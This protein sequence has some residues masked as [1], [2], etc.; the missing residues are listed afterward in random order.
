MPGGRG[1]GESVGT[2]PVR[3]VAI[4][5]VLLMAFAAI[6]AALVW[7]WL[8]LRQPPLADPAPVIRTS[9]AT[10]PVLELCGIE[11]V[12]PTTLSQTCGD[13]SRAWNNVH[14]WAWDTTAAF[15]VGE[16]WITQSDGNSAAYPVRLELSTASGAPTDTAG[17]TTS[18]TRATGPTDG[19]GRTGRSGNRYTRLTMTYSAEA[20]GSPTGRQVVFDI[21]TTADGTQHVLA[22]EGG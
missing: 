4:V 8:S 18:A 12:Q 22:Q 1:S 6:V 13:G 10:G 2:V 11:Y 9:T 15:A 3:L 20:P 17:S 5:G 21:A 14:W 19:T 7:G 16:Y